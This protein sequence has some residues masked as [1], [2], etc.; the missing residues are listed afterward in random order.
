MIVVSG[1]NITR[2]I[3]EKFPDPINLPRGIF[4]I[5]GPSVQDLCV[6]LDRGHPKI[7]PVESE[8]VGQG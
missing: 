6:P 4:S 8:E 1:T 7:G 3:R 5:F 2:T